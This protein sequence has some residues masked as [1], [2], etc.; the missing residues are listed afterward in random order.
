[1]SSTKRNNKF[2]S[3]M[4]L[5]LISLLGK[6]CVRCGTTANLV[7]HHKDKNDLNNGLGNFEVLCKSCHSKEHSGEYSKGIR[8]IHLM[9]KLGLRKKFDIGESFPTI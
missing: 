9:K 3:D 8:K 6:K 4:R 2:G 7:L 1:M 5:V